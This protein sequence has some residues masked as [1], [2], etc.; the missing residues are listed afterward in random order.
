VF[1]RV[2]P[3]RNPVAAARAILEVLAM[4]DS[5]EL[6]ELLK[7]PKA[8][9]ARMEANET[10]RK[11]RELGAKFRTFVIENFGMERYLKE[12]EQQLFLGAF[13]CAERRVEAM[14]VLENVCVREVEASLIRHMRPE[15]IPSL[16]VADSLGQAQSLP[17]Y[18]LYADAT[19]RMIETAMMK[20]KQNFLKELESH[21]TTMQTKKT[22]APF[23][24]AFKN[25]KSPNMRRNSILKYYMSP[26]VFLP[27]IL[28]SSSPAFFNKKSSLGMSG[29]YGGA[30]TPRTP[31]SPYPRY[32][33]DT[34]QFPNSPARR[35][36]H[37]GSGSSA[38]LTSHLMEMFANDPDRQK[39]VQDL[40]NALVGRLVRVPNIDELMRNMDAWIESCS[41]NQSYEDLKK[42]LEE[43]QMIICDEEGKV[44]ENDRDAANIQYERVFAQFTKTTEY[45]TEIAR[46][47]EEKRRI[48]EPLNRAAWENLI[49]V[50]S[51][52]NIKHEPAIRDRLKENP[53]LG[54][55]CMDPK[56]IG[57]KHQG[58]FQMYTLNNLSEEELRAI[59]AILPK[60][61][62]DQ[63]R[64]A[65][66]TD[67]LEN[68][69]DQLAKNGPKKPRAERKPAAPK[70]PLGPP[71]APPK[72]PP[73]PGK[74]KKAAAAV[75]AGDV[76]AE[77]LAKRKKLG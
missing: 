14:T 15:V 75:P 10:I 49:K 5:A 21:N 61:R 55:I 24:V 32:D 52:E 70:P 76:F 35:T 51:R 67:A 33:G 12:H 71:G 23:H 69:I 11:R 17:L 26:A 16:P 37:E 27:K 40:V 4:C 47:A 18:D 59:R 60:W 62:S 30:S 50:F 7:D 64:Q 28:G 25:P 20:N 41:T 65:A 43:L 72:A 13:R 2:V 22:I 44:S 54:L 48:N 3:P 56:A 9:M 38:L 63:T 19:H 53:E 29:G 6:D 36:R 66:W 34:P 8:L 68:K 46:I 73:A 77:L 74:A 39:K 57:M 31:R 45:Q 42:Q 58:D 1:G